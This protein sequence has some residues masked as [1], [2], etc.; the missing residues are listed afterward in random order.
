[1]ND[2]K[3][4]PIPSPL[5]DDALAGSS[6]HNPFAAIMVVSWCCGVVVRRFFMLLFLFMLLFGRR[7]ANFLIY[8]NLCITT[9]DMNAGQYWYSSNLTE[10]PYLGCFHL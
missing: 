3:H 4:L 1:M 8:M 5:S 9:C 2:K 6:T 7:A 10:I